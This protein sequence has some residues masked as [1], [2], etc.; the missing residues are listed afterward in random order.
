MPPLKNQRHELFAQALAKG[1]TGDEAYAAAGF[2]RDRRNASRLTTNDAIKNRVAELVEPAIRKTKITIE[3]LLEELIPIAKQDMADF[4]DWNESG[5]TLKDSSTLPE[6]KTKLVAEVTQVMN[7]HGG[8]TKFK[9]HDKLGAIKLLGQYL[10][11]FSDRIELTGKDGDPIEIANSAR[12]ELERALAKVA[13]GAAR[14]K[15]G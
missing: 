15:R 8:T 11:M 4:V 3:E 2:S 13:S 5:V 14:S 9:L 6:G 10:K 12:D 1:K 7:E